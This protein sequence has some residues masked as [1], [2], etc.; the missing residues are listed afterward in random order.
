MLLQLKQRS[1][2]PDKTQAIKPF[3]QPLPQFANQPSVHG[4]F[5]NQPSI[6]G[7]I[8]ITCRRTSRREVDLRVVELAEHTEHGSQWRPRSNMTGENYR[9]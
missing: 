7:T 9:T 3:L 1:L 8:L 5:A 2:M 4:I 6:H